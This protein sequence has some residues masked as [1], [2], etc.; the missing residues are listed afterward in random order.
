MRKKI[1]KVRPYDPR[2]GK[3]SILGERFSRA[4][5]R[6]DVLNNRFLNLFES[7]VGDEIPLDV[8]EIVEGTLQKLRKDLQIAYKEADEGFQ[9]EVSQLLEKFDDEGEVF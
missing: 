6:A 8:K 3:A 9:N 2:F 4:L 1:V 7:T 5:T